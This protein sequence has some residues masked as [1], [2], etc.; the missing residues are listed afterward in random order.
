M[1]PVDQEG[2][3]ILSCIILSVASKNRGVLIPLYS[4]LLSLHLEYRVQ[5]W[6]P[7]CNEDIKPLEH[8]QRSVMK[9]VR[10]LK[11]KSYEE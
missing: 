3:E 9:V 8:V 10:D 7:H 5:F 11:H 6:V 4:A 2:N 1:C